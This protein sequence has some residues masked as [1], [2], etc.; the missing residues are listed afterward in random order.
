MF[1]KECIIYENKICDQC[2]DC[3]FCD[4]NPD[5]I[6]DNCGLCLEDYDYSAIQVDELIMDR[7][8][9]EISSEYGSQMW[10]FPRNEYEDN[11][12]NVI[13]IDDVKGL[14]EALERSEAEEDGHDHDCCSHDHDHEHLY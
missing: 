11:D 1:H 10:R 13:F 5:K 6:C 8:K 2:G 3:N 4:L 14:R 9:D 12:D 7:E